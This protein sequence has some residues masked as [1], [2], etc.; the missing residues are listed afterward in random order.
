MH[1]V[2]GQTFTADRADALRDAAALAGTSERFDTSDI[3]EGGDMDYATSG[4]LSPDARFN[5]FRPSARAAADAAAKS[6]VLSFESRKLLAMDSSIASKVELNV[7]VSAEFDEEFGGVRVL[8]T[9][10]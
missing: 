4:L 3:V 2:L 6:A 5:R 1:G 10:D 7:D 9:R 8:V